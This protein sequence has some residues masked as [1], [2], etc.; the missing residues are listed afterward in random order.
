MKFST[1]M[2]AQVRE[3]FVTG[4][5]EHFRSEREV[6]VLEIE[7]QLRE[8][9]VEM[10]AQSLGAYLSGQEASYP[11]ERI[12][13]D[14]GGE[15]E[16]VS[17]KKAKV[18]S[19]FGW[20]SYRRA[21]YLCPQ[22]HQGQKPLDRQ[23]GLEPGQATSGLADL[24]GVAGVQTSFDE[25][26]QL[27][28]R[29]LLV[30]VSEN[31]LRKATQVFG[32]LQDQE[33]VKWIEA[34]QD[35]VWLQ[36]HV[37]T[38]NQYPQRLYGSIDGAQAPLNEEWREMKTGCWF[39]V[40]TIK[41]ARVP[42]YRQ[43][44]VGELGTLKAKDISYYCDLEK[45]GQFGKL[46]W[47]TGCKRLADCVPEIVFVADGAAWI[48][49]LVELYYPHAIQIVDWFHAESYLKPI[50]KALFDNDPKVVQEWLE[51]TR[52][53]LWEGEVQKVITSCA[54]LINHPQAGQAAQKALTYYT[55]NQHRMDYASFR[56]AG[57][58]IGS[59]TVE[60]ACKQIVSQRLK[61]PGARWTEAGARLTAKARAAWLSGQWNHLV[62]LRSH[63]PLAA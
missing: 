58:M 63:L 17:Y 15:S 54:K 53:A 24:L 21:Y 20:A 29:Y 28:M 55:N 40:E 45:A 38:E 9:L 50:A 22:C 26:S 34:S 1:E 51:K 12:G 37:R 52:T 8:M 4:L 31:T 42:Q 62:H 14:C 43:A 41:K 7:T 33:E 2:Q 30:E 25:G 18:K 5:E 56:D 39:E 61:R 6:T 27:V 49:N 35:P 60:S 11:P 44:K 57:Y 59:G 36:E 23:L 13:C 32:Q 3:I 16:Y 19:V 10:G 48:W 46:M 47:P